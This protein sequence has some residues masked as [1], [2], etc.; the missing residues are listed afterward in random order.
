[1]DEKASVLD[2]VGEVEDIAPGEG[3]IL[4]LDLEPGAYL[5]I[6]NILGH[7]GQ[8]MVTRFTVR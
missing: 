7:F 6:C 8:G 3:A 5:A 2:V 1:V 4:E